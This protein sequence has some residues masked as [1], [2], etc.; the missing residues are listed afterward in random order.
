M[1]EKLI[2]AFR[3][4][5]SEV[6]VQYEIDHPDQGISARVVA[7][8]RV[9][10]PVTGWRQTIYSKRN[11]RKIKAFIRRKMR[12]RLEFY[13]QIYRELYQED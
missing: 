10:F 8:D 12:R 1:V 9:C 13:R 4:K 2:F 5:Q 6:G 7:T 11:A 3:V